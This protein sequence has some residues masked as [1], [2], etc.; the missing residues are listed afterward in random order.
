MVHSQLKL[1]MSEKHNVRKPSFGPLVKGN[2]GAGYEGAS[3]LA[4]WVKKKKWRKGEKP[5]GQ[6]NQNRTPPLPP[7]GPA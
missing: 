4:P 2:E 1:G 6:V 7:A 5:A 3:R